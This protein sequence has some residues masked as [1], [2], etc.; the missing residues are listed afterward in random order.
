MKGIKTGQVR[1]I[2]RFIS[3]KMRP[4]ENRGFTK[5]G[6]TNSPVL[7]GEKGQRCPR[8]GRPNLATY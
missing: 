1:I 3:K 8:I 4:A 5:I 6:L 2:N 7:A